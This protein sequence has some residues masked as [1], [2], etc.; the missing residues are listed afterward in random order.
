M[1]KEL[2]AATVAA[3]RAGA[4]NVHNGTYTV[5]SKVR[6]HFTVKL[7]TAQKGDLA[8][9]R[10]LSIL[11]GPDN[12]TAFTGIAFWDDGKRL[13]TV[14]RRYRGPES[15]MPI[16]GFHW[17]PKGWS[18]YEQ[19]LAIWADLAVRGA[20]PERHGFWHGEGYTMEL[21]GRCCRCNRKLTHPESIE[22]GLGP[23]CAQIISAQRGSN[24]P[25]IEEP[26]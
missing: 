5:A 17:Q 12:E 23:E 19:K 21:E 3:I 25:Q 24:E 4:P 9:R 11:T 13:V 8:G 14:W 26:A 18:A 22:M 2:D 6:G 16:D 15:S 20:T 10:M 1:A 7:W